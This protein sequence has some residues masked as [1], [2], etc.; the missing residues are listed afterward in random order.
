MDEGIGNV[1]AALRK[2]GMWENTLLIF[3]SDNGGASFGNNYPLRGGKYSPF[4]GGVRVLTF[5]SGG[6]LPAKAAGTTFDGLVHISDW[7]PTLCA[8]AGVDGTD[9]PA[10][11]K[12]EDWFYP[13]DGHDVWSFMTSGAADPRKGSEPVVLSSLITSGPGGGSMINGHHKIVID[14]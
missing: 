12:D 7:Y 2:K 1:T 14:T 6:F 13:V 3:T 5:M 4:E 11:D 9:N 10:S 8:L